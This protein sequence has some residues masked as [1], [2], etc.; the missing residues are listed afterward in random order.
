LRWF[1][2]W[3]LKHFTCIMY[4]VKSESSCVQFVCIFKICKTK[5][6]VLVTILNFGILTCF[7]NGTKFSKWRMWCF[8]ELL[9]ENYWYFIDI[10]WMQRYQMFFG[11]LEETWTVFSTINFLIKQIL[12]NIGSRMEIEEYFSLVEIFTNSKRCKLQ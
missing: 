12:R 7:E 2:T 3:T 8:Y 5:K 9:I 11:V 10:R 4:F 1:C 6:N